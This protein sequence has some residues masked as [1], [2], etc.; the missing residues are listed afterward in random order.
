MLTNFLIAILAVIMVEVTSLGVIYFLARKSGQT[1]RQFIL[2]RFGLASSSDISNLKFTTRMTD[3]TLFSFLRTF[4]KA[5]QALVFKNLLGL[6]A[7]PK[8]RTKKVA[9]RRALRLSK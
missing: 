2:G 4:P 1:V 5:K 6:E 3:A 8:K 9:T 7:K